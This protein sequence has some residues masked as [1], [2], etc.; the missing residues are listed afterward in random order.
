METK[1]AFSLKRI[2]IVFVVLVIT[3]F[4]SEGQINYEHTYTGVSAAYIHLPLAG[5]KYYVMDVA[6]CQCRMYNNDH[7]LWKTI[8]LS[9]PSGYY[10]CDI[11]FVTED[12]FNTDNTI[13]MLYV[14]YNYNTTLKYYTY[15]TRIVNEY[16]TILLSMPYAGYS[17]IYPAETGSKL[18]MWIY[19][20]SVFPEKVNTMVYSI[21]GKL[22]S[23]VT[24][25]SSEL[26][27]S[28]RSAYPNPATNEVTIPYYLPSNVKQAELKLYSMNGMLVKSFTVDHTFNTVQVK[29]GDL[30]AGLYVYRIESNTFKSE[31]Y[32]LT[33][34]K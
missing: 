25:S 11:Q 9:I 5:Y 14:S 26:K 34:S 16:G 23:I 19:D 2:S 12:L 29:T 32:K 6:N 20:F 13:E 10:L 31:S 33:V 21:P 4:N 30:P 8:N 3:A 1:I 27:S 17:Y 24:G 15:D 22:N 28:L 18:F 7:S